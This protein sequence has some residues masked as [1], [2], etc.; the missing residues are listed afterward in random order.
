MR[1]P[2]TLACSPPCSRMTSPLI[3]PAVTPLPNRKIGPAVVVEAGTLAHEFVGDAAES[4]TRHGQ[5]PLVLRLQRWTTPSER[6]GNSPARC[7]WSQGAGRPLGWAGHP[8][9]A[10]LCPL[11][12]HGHHARGDVDPKPRPRAVVG[13]G[14]LSICLRLYFC[15]STRKWIPRTERA[16]WLG[17]LQN[18]TGAVVL[19]SLTCHQWSWT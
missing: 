3:A 17:R 18:A 15:I 11:H 16:P 1:T 8:P 4:G 13:V 5:R 7:W 19:S 12:G 9:V 2:V 10:P 14:H 6:A